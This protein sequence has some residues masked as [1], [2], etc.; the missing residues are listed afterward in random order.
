[1]KISVIT[2]CY[3]CFDTIEDTILSVDA[4]D[5]PHKEHIIIDGGSDDGT[6]NVI[7]K[8]RSK[9]SYFISEKDNGIYHAMNKGVVAANGCIVGMLNGDDTYYD[10]TCLSAVANEF[11]K[12]RVSIVCGDLICVS[13]CDLS[14][15]LRH[16][17]SNGFKPSMFRTG[18]MPPHPASFILKKCYEQ[19]GGYDE[20]YLI[21]GDFELL[22]RFMYVQQISYSCFSKKIVKMRNGGVSNKNL[23]SRW[24]LNKEILRA[25]SENG[26][27]TN[28][29]KVLSK[30]FNKI[31][32]YFNLS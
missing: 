31:P 18:I 27:E 15:P 11:K 6:I 4:Q 16:Y 14:K 8:H 1:M 9:I 21:S 20:S 5:Y 17:S 26:V 3:N 7:K 12:H 25:C 22:L 13:N 30:Y 10:N 2:V 23:K 32:Q 19:Y 24:I 29:V 28:L